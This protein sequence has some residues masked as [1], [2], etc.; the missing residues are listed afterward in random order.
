[1]LIIYVNL[2]NMRQYHRNKFMSHYDPVVDPIYVILNF[3]R[4][5]KILIYKLKIVILWKYYRQ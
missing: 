3:G 1:M 5:K 2:I 4:T